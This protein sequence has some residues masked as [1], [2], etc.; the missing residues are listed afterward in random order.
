MGIREV[1]RQLEFESSYTLVEHAPE[2]SI[3]LEILPQAME[4]VRKLSGAVSEGRYEEL[5]EILGRH[6]EKSLPDGLGQDNNEEFRI[7]EGLLVG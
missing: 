6:P 2:D 4:Q 5:L 3:Q 1:S 7:V